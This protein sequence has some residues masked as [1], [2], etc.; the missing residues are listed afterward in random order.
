MRVLPLTLCLGSG[1]A[2]ESAHGGLDLISHG[3]KSADNAPLQAISGGR[4]ASRAT[5][6]RTHHRVHWSPSSKVSAS[7]S[8]PQAARPYS[9]RGRGTEFCI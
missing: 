1:C 3:R 2:T 7:E 8:E 4:A 6:R 5:R 9:S